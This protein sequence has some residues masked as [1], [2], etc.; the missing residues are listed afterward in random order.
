MAQHTS[1]MG[2]I[3]SFQQ[4]WILIHSSSTQFNWEIT[5][6][7]NVKSSIFS[8]LFT[9]N[10]SRCKFIHIRRFWMLL[11]NLAFDPFAKM[12]LSFPTQIV[13]E[14]ENSR[15]TFRRP[16]AEPN[17]ITISRSFS[18]FHSNKYTLSCVRYHFFLKIQSIF[19]CLL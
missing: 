9:M 19:F 1:G 15:D 13:I 18:V 8:I 17:V 4:R 7:H 5:S 14:F 11:I 3:L 10:I 2:Q 16:L 12:A 6:V